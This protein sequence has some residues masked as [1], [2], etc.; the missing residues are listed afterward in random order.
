MCLSFAI[1]K[2]SDGFW[3]VVTV[4]LAGNKLYMKNRAEAV[5]HYTEAIKLNPL[6]VSVS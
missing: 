1:L 3:L 4:C 2:M 6:D 5:K